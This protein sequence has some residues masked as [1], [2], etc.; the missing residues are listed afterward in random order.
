M[1]DPV[2]EEITVSRQCEL[3]GL[4]RSQYYY[5]PKGES[6]ENLDLMLKIDKQYIKTPFYGVPKMCVHLSSFGKAVN[7]KR[8]RR[9]MRLMGLE[10]IYSKPRLSTPD[11]AH[12][13]YP[14][15][16]KGLVICRINQVWSID[17]TYIPMVKG[18]MYLVAVIDWYSR[19]VLS[20]KL[21][22]SLEVSFC[23]DA[24]EESFNYGKPEIF[25]TDQGGQFTS[26]IF[27]GRL[28]ARE[29]LISMDGRGRA[30]DNIFVERLWRT[31]K[32][33]YVY[34]HVQEDVRELF[35]GLKEYFYFYN[36]ERPHQSLGYKTPSEVYFGKA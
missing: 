10:A 9:L 21:S 2:S 15:L 20:W 36:N 29:I 14:Y 28:E 1:I 32:Y 30:F 5:Q 7:I 18:F 34:L 33:E 12:A 13:K 22:N 35:F 23:L 3:I 19:Y 24:L 17:I 16:L 27:T 31:V 6:Q 8:V 11:K 26:T 4:N 25:N